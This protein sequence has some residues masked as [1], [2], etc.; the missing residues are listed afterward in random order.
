MFLAFRETS[1]GMFLSKNSVASYFGNVK[2]SSGCCIRLAPPKIASILDKHCA[3]RGT[4]Y[5]LQAPPRTKSDLRALSTAILK[6]ATSADDYKDAALLNMLWY[7]L[8]RS[9]D[10]LALMKNQL[11]VNPG[12]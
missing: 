10:T 1:K 12:M 7:L 8:G 4:E 5:T 11:A 6:G 2:N 9:S 3:K